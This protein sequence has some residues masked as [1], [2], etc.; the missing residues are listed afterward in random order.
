MI[1]G[2]LIPQEVDSV[3]KFLEKNGIPFELTFN[4]EGA[5]QELQPSPGNNIL[6][7]ELR[8]KTYLA[9]HFYIDISEE[10][11]INNPKVEPQLLALITKDVIPETSQEETEKRIMSIEVRGRMERR[12]AR[13]KFMQK[14]LAILFLI[15]MLY[16]M[17]SGLIK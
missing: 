3:I 12:A 1:F 17:F 6:Y 13:S 8:T 11:L 2:P 5:R 16:S 9:Q 10:Y 14:L 7:S 4:D 15:G